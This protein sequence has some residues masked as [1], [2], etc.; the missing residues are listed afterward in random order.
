[1]AAFAGALFDRCAAQQTA[2]VLNGGSSV[3]L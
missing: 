1:V 2:W 3:A